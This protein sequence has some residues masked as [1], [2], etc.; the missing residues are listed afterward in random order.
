ML[1]DSVKCNGVTMSERINTVTLEERVGHRGCLTQDEIA[2]IN[3]VL[4]HYQ[5]NQAAC[6]EALKAVQRHRGW[7]N[8]EALKA[9]ASYLKLSAEDVEGVATFYNLIYRQKVG[10]HVIRVCDSV[11]CWM[12]GYEKV[13]EA[14]TSALH[15]EMGGSTDDG[16]FTL[17][18]GP[19]FGAC[20]HAPVLM[21][22][23]VYHY[24]INAE[25]IAELLL[26]YDAIPSDILI[27]G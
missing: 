2:E 13:V 3:E 24:N 4:A 11:S 26:E 14:L 1:I 16:E 7:V 6:I 15:I 27:K 10:R 20:D 23:D 19:C 12:L 21:I 18:P 8:N 25:K 22:N 9:V 17:L 5:Y